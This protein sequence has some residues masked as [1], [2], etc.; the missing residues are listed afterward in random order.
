MS[1]RSGAFTVRM[2]ARCPDRGT[3]L[4]VDPAH[5]EK[6]VLLNCLDGGQHGAARCQV[7]PGGDGRG[8]KRRI[9]FRR[10]PRASED[11]E[12]TKGLTPAAHGSSL[13]APVCG[14]SQP[15]TSPAPC[16]KV[17]VPRGGQRN[18]VQGWDWGLGLTLK[19]QH[20]T[21]KI[22]ARSLYTSFMEMS[23]QHCLPLI[24]G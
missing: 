23:G 5:N 4:Q 16:C 15:H 1:Y 11:S 21:G 13:R 20:S 6:L 22:K 7:L 24:W 9:A 8:A 3:G 12:G 17:P 2:G 14:R 18:Q 10:C 19:A